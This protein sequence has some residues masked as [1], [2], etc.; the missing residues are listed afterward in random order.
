M[1]W[2]NMKTFLKLKFM[3]FY[4]I[5]Q[6]SFWWWIFLSF[7][8]F[9]QTYTISLHQWYVIKRVKIHPSDKFSSQ[10]W[11]FIKL[12]IFKD[13]C[14]FICRTKFYH[15]DNLLLLL[16]LG[17][18]LPKNTI[19]SK[20]APHLLHKVDVPPSKRRLVWNYIHF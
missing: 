11:V 19:L 12:M 10:L 15:T 14:I 9:Y 8:R 17:L 4:Q 16:Q 7:M 18:S 6:F 3:S 5:N 1:L 2:K 20:F 13:L